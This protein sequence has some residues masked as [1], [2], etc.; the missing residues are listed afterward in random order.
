M[1]SIQLGFDVT[2][3]ISTSV[4]SIEGSARYSTGVRLLRSSCE[5]VANFAKALAREFSALDICMIWTS[6]NFFSKSL[7]FLRYRIIFSLLAS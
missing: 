6:T 1:G 5:A 3:E 4:I 2:G 7:T